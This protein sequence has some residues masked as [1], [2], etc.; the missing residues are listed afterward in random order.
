M[1]K[2]RETKVKVTI[3]YVD[4]N[5]QIEGFMNTNDNFYSDKINLYYTLLLM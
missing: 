1:A 3:R 2:V 4:T 5:V